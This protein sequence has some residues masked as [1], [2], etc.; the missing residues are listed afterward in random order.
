MIDETGELNPVT[1]YGQSK[2]WAERDIAVLA[3]DGFSPT[4]LRPAT[5]YGVSPRLRLDVVLNNLVACAL[6][7][8]LKIDRY[9]QLAFAVQ[10]VRA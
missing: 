3:G 7:R 1:I 8:V 9:S 2:V 10:P 4:F 6:T 5:A